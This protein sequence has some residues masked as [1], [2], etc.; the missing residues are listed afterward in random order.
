MPRWLEGCPSSSAVLLPEARLMDQVVAGDEDAFAH[1]VA[2]YE[3]A[4]FNY[5]HHMTQ[6]EALTAD[7]MQETWLH[8]WQHARRYNATRPFLP[9]VYRIA[10][11]C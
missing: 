11:H 6:D 8:V 10:H 4:L 5:L 7:L 2:R 1:L 9:W 3:R